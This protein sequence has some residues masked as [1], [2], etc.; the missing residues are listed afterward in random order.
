[1]IVLLI[2][3]LIARV[4][5]EESGEGSLLVILQKPHR[6]VLK[7]HIHSVHTYIYT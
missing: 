4:K 5:T 6:K 1:M 3:C 2:H 7:R